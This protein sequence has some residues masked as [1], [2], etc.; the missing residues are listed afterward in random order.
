MLLFGQ[1]TRE[2]D[3]T[4]CGTHPGTIAHTVGTADGTIPGTMAD[5][6]VPDGIAG[7]THGTIPGI[8]TGILPGITAGI[9]RTAMA[10]MVMQAI[11]AGIIPPTITVVEAA[12][13]TMLATVLP[14]HS[15]TDVSTSMVLAAFPTAVLPLI[16]PAHSAVQA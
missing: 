3:T 12:D 13:I 14:V 11:T 2:V 15:I 1:A 6:L 9:I 4:G 16:A 10:T 7:T 5:I 8:T